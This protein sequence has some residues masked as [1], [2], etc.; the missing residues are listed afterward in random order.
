MNTNFKPRRLAVLGAIVIL[1]NFEPLVWGYSPPSCGTTY[2]DSWYCVSNGSV[3]NPGGLTKTNEIGYVGCGVSTPALTNTTFNNGLKAQSC[4]NDCRA[5]TN[6]QPV[7]YTPTNW[8][9]PPLPAVFTNTGTFCY[10]NKVKGIT[11]DTNCPSPTATVIVG[12][13]TVTVTNSRPLIITQP[14]DQV[15]ASGGTVYLRV[16]A[17]GTGP[18]NYQWS[19]NG[20]NL[21]GATGATLLLTNVQCSQSGSYAVTITNIYGSTNSADAVVTV[22]LTPPGMVAWWRGENNALDSAGTNNG[23]LVGGMSY[24]AGEVGQGFVFDGSTAYI[25]IPASPSLNVGLSGGLTIEGWI[26]PTNF[27]ASLFCEWYN[28]GPYN[29]QFFGGHTGAFFICVPNGEMLG[30]LVDTSCGGHAI[31]TSAGVITTNAWQHV[32]MTYDHA[33]GVAALYCNGVIVASQNLGSFTPQTSSDLFLGGQPDPEY[34]IDGISAGSIDELSIYN[35]AL[36]SNEIAGI[37]LAGNGGKCSPL[38]TPAIVTQPANQTVTAGEIVTFTVTA[39]GGSPLSYQWWFNGTNIAGATNATLTLTDVWSIN[40]GNY[41]VVISNANSSVTSSNAAL[42]VIGPWIG[43]PEGDLNYLVGAA[44]KVIDRSAAVIGSTN[45]SSFSGYRLTVSL[46]TNAQPEDAL[47]IN[48]QGNSSN[49]VG[50]TNSY[51]MYGGTTIGTFSGGTGTNA[52]VIDLTNS[53]TVTAAMMQAL[54]RDIA[55]RYYPSTNEFL[56]SRTVQFVL[57]DCQGNTTL[58]ATKD[59]FLECPRYLDVMLVIDNSGSMG[60]SLGGANSKL[61]AA[62]AAAISFIDQDMVFTNDQVGLVT[63]STTAANRSGLTNNPSQVISIINGLAKDNTTDIGDGIACAQADFPTNVPAGTLPVMILLTDGLPNEPAGTNATNYCIIKANLAKQAGT[64][65]ITIGLGTNGDIDVNLLTTLASSPSD[66]IWATNTDALL[67]IYHSIGCTFCRP[68]PT[69]QI[70]SPT[71][72]ALY[73]FGEPITFSAMVSDPFGNV[74][75]VQFFNGI[76]LLATPVGVS[77]SYTFTWTNAP[78]GTNSLTAMATNYAGLCIT[79]SVVSIFVN[80]TPQVNAGDNQTLVWVETNAINTV[81]LSGTAFDPDNLPDPLTTTWSVIGSNGPVTFQN[82]TAPNTLAYFTTHGTYILQ[83]TASDGAT[84]VSSNCTI[85]IKRRPFVTITSPTNNLTFNSGTPIIIA[86]TAYDLDGSVTSVQFY[87]GSTLLATPIGMGTNY[88]FTWSNAPL[89]TDL[90][91]AVACDNDGLTNVS[92]VSV[93]VS[94]SISVQLVNPTNTQF[95]VASPT[96]IWL[97]AT[98]SVSGGYVTSVQFSNGTSLLGSG[99]NATGNTWK[100]LWWGANN[101]SYS[102]TAHAADN[103]GHTAVSSANAIVVN[104]MPV[105]TI[106]TPTN[107]QSYW[108]TSSVTLSASAFDPDGT[109]VQVQFYCYTQLW[110]TITNIG[111]NGWY[112]FTIN[113]L[114]PGF[115][116]ITAMATDTNGAVSCSPMVIFEVVSTNSPPTVYITYP[117]N[118]A[119]FAPGSDITITADATNFP[120]SVTNVEFFVNGESIG[121]DPDA[122]YEIKRCCWG[123]GSYTLTAKATDNNGLWSVATNV[124]ITITQD[125]PSDEGFWDPE[126]GQPLRKFLSFSGGVGQGGLSLAWSSVDS[127]P[128]VYAGLTSSALEVIDGTNWYPTAFQQEADGG[129]WVNAPYYALFADGTNIYTFGPSPW[130]A[131][132]TEQDYRL[133]ETSWRTND[134]VVFLGDQLNIPDSPCPGFSS[135][136]PVRG[137]IKVAGDIY[138]CGDFVSSGSPANTDVQ[139]IAKLDKTNDRWIRVGD[140]LDGPVAAMAA[141]NNELYIGGAFTHT[142]HNLTN[143]VNYIAWL[144]ADNTWKSLGSGVAVIPPPPGSLTNLEDLIPV[145]ALAVCGTNLFVGGQFTTAGDDTN[146]NGIAIWNTVSWRGMNGGPG[147]TTRYDNPGHYWGGNIYPDDSFTNWP[148]F[149]VNTISIHGDRVYV[150]GDFSYVVNGNT[151]DMVTVAITDNT[152]NEYFGTQDVLDLVVVPNDDQSIVPAQGIALAT[153]NASD[154][155]WH[156]SGLDSGIEGYANSEEAVATVNSSIIVPGDNPGCYDLYIAGNF[157][158]AGESHLSSIGLAR[159]RVGYP[160]PPTAPTV[161][162]TSPTNNA[163]FTYGSWVTITAT[164]TS[165]YA[166]LNVVDIYVDGQDCSSVSFT[167]A[168]PYSYTNIWSTNNLPLGVHLAKAV[169]TD[170]NGLQGESQPVVFS[171]KDPNNTIIARDDHYTIPENSPTVIF[172]VLTN[173]TYSS[174]N[175]VTIN[176]I[177][178]PD[179]GLGIAR[180]GYGGA[181]VLYTPLPYVYGT[182]IFYY[183]ITNASGAFDTASVT[184]N[185]FPP[186]TVGIGHPWNGSIYNADAI[187]SVSG[188]AFGY[189]SVIAWMDVYANGTHINGSSTN[190]FTFDWSFHLPGFYTFVA[191]ATDNHGITGS[192]SPVT[193][194]IT[195]YSTANNVLTATIDNLPVNVDNHTGTATYHIVEQGL[196]D[197]QGQ[198][199]DSI[200]TNPVTY[201]LLLFPADDPDSVIANVTPQPLDVA[202]FH[203]GGDTNND[204]GML[205]LTGFPNG[206]YDLVL[207]VHGGGAQKCCTNTF[208]LDSQ[209]KIGQFSFSEQDLV[210]PV[211]GIPLTIT[212]TY[213]SLNPNSSDFGYGWTFAMNNLDVQ[214]DEVRDTV[215]VDNDDDLWFGGDITPTGI[216]TMSVRTGGGWDVTLTLPNGQETTFAFS[217]VSYDGFNGEAQWT[218]PPRVHA[219]LT[220][221]IDKPFDDPA[222]ITF[223]PVLCWTD[224]IGQAWDYNDV[225]LQNQDFPGW[226]LTTQPDNTR[227]YI[228]RGSP[229]NVACSIIY[230]VP[231]YARVYGAPKLTQIVSRSGDTNQIS[232]NGITHYD[233]TGHATRSVAFDRDYAGRITAIYDPNG[234]ATGFPAVQYVY[235]W[236]T[237]DLVQVLKLVDSNAGTYT[238]NKYHYDNPYFPHYITSIENGDGVPVARNYYDDSG[239][240]VATQDANGNLT[241]FIHSTTNNAELVIDRLGNTNSYI[242]DPRGNVTNQINALGQMTTMAYDANNNKTNSIIYNENGDPYATNSYLYDGNNLLLASTDPLG[243]TNGFTYNG[244]GQV[245]TSADALGNSTVNTYDSYGNLIS[246]TDALGHGTTNF[247]SYG[248]LTGSIDSLG[249]ITTN[250]YDS[251]GN[252]RSTIT[253]DSSCVTLSSSSFTYDDNGNRRTSTVSRRVN[254]NWVDATTRFVYDGQNRVVQTIDPDVGTNTVVY[255]LAGKQVA[256]VDKLGNTTSYAYDG[257]GRLLIT[258]YPDSTMETNGYNA[259][260][261]RVASADRLGRITTYAYD[262]L[263]RL[264]NAVYPDSATSATIYDDVGRVA[265]TIDARGTITVFAYDAAGR[266]LAVTNAVGT[267]CASSSSY[268]YDANGNQIT[269]TDANNHTITNVFDALNRQVQVQYPDGTI[270]GTSYDAAGRRIAQTNQAYITTG[271]GYDGA[272]RLTSVTN[273]LGTSVQTVT[274]YQYDEAGNEIA[275]IDALNRNNTYAY[276]CMGRRI[277]HTLPGGQ[278]EGFAYDLAGNLIFATNFNH[279]IITNQYDVMNRLTNRA[280]VNGYQ[281]SYT[282]TI[283]GQRATMTDPSGSTSYS[284]D[285][286]DRL[287]NKVVNWGNPVVLSVSLNHRYDA[288]GNLTNL[289]SSTSGGATNVYQY[290]ALNRLTNVVG[291]ASSLSQ[292]TYDDAG[293]LKSMRYGN[294]VTNRYQYDSLNRL[295]NNIWKLNSSVLA[296]FTY[297][298]GATGNRVGLLETNNGA[299]RNY[300]WNYDALYRLTNEIVSGTAP[301]GNLGYQYDV[302]GNRTNRNGSL[303]A[304]GSQALAYNTNDW[305][306]TDAYDSNGNTLWSTNGTGQGPYCYDVENRLTNYANTVYLTYNGDGNRVS[307]KV[308]GTT[309]YYLLDDRNP[310]GF[311]QV[312]EEWTSTGT[313][314]LS[315]VYNYGLSLI[316]QKQGGTTYYFICD[317][318]GSTRAL[319][320]GGGSFVNAF[321]YDAFGVLIASNG[322]PQTAYLYC[323]EYLDPDLGFYHLRAPREYNPQTGRFTT[324]DTY[325]GNNEDP[326]SLHKYLYVCDNPVNMVDPSGQDGTVMELSISGNLAAGLAAFS[327]AAVYEAKT[328]A[329]STLTRAVAIESISM[330]DSVI[331]TARSAI[332]A[333]GKSL[334]DLIE[335]AKTQIGQLRNSP[336]KVIPMPRS[337]IPGVAAHIASAQSPPTTKPMLLERCSPGQAVLN[338]AAAIKGISS[339]GPGYSLDE[340]P[341][342]SS[343]QGGVGASVAAVPFWENCV[344]GG[345]IGACYTIEKIT[346]GTPYYVVVTP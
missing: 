226:I 210:L 273:A 146:V 193:I 302:V 309:T 186:P 247:Y 139:Y 68:P 294:G 277:A 268:G 10:T 173:D 291:Q 45:C 321:A 162:I 137:I 191:T 133:L 76:N 177:F 96:N 170:Q 228:T 303:G 233:P 62:K 115:Y 1:L 29:N 142:G 286:R 116:P 225:P 47:V 260:G 143:Q 220:P 39:F 202:G 154:Q 26:N 190:T 328:H 78:L 66:F 232:D 54:V 254:G 92:Q 111:T 145:K 80:A 114:S 56:V 199:R 305:L 7:T 9:Q 166:N 12:I 69:I 102:L 246:T 8:W 248:L 323:G 240:L 156:W 27:G 342:A 329:L 174:T 23:V 70:I 204:L 184:V 230:G 245:L 13:Y 270:T 117:T 49:Q 298:L 212:R 120:A 87:N 28:N 209:L 197:L 132:Q 15:A 319:Y 344:Q 208:R 341:F 149:T 288:N 128:I 110:A 167:R 271:F 64:R 292:Y 159:W 65:L 72:N 332:R 21:A 301:T 280:S 282:Y 33:S 152:Y 234:N 122:P 108:E 73:N 34:G 227:Y 5:W 195:N 109:N 211:N 95:F 206:M 84:S 43:L 325:A 216:S 160:W 135:S 203:Q 207:I 61:S 224:T 52:M 346:P 37:Y 222:Q 336:V 180:I 219:T 339:A 67:P 107:L 6:S 185:I 275:Q 99:T 58:P 289:W 269:F 46:I 91:K 147:T 112:N 196:F 168:G 213:N 218:A 86:A 255:D 57:T 151:Q 272:G 101:G 181:S 93:I 179:S 31:Y 19:L 105:V 200:V 308:G 322:A 17:V 131:D 201:Q 243:H 264:T 163:L 293:N 104:A 94:P 283:T 106:V 11:A 333:A 267:S 307:K 266:R 144:G 38:M 276:D 239:R 182:D 20:T 278:S 189:D 237:G 251:A 172:N 53:V 153:W 85:T 221:Y 123:T 30:Q 136:I 258:T 311:V 75:N 215:T 310:S 82:V 343:I 281:V 205:D 285:S 121:S 74:T 192:S 18:L 130:L 229:T 88:T 50:G 337:I 4:Q 3:N 338:R 126:F 235:D 313:P 127:K 217:V 300:T 316:S 150:G 327:M 331:E 89:G 2:C 274:R 242:Y 32:A 161:A 138:I 155:L 244:Y 158:I 176:Q 157:I 178:Q 187:I 340:Y 51:V 129:T 250:A 134:S 194:A 256:T 249:T 318:H 42:T 44:P 262:A 77:N 330:G 259:N 90:L 60:D 279:V 263:N 304:L 14:S 83:L 253:M 40:A 335:E 100:F 119:S 140:G 16:G 295:T 257:Q 183:A 71:D 171:I 118:G 252:L 299:N 320:D 296:S 198:A 188:S 261:N 223:W 241:Q 141:M 175:P 48:N 63:F 326:L 334:R 165:S 125:E 287:T 214:L 236:Y 148:P 103:L 231:V 324:S 59:I 306:K 265:Q 24:G 164:A 113:K 35:R 290:D 169:A 79:S 124:Q 98:T 345:I 238:T 315:K 25:D 22:V 314:S 297:T 317:G 81:A 284:Y 312:L 55:Y 97:T 36:S 41:C